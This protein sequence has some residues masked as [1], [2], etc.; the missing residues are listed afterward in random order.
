MYGTPRY[1]KEEIIELLKKGAT[2]N[3]IF[4]KFDIPPSTLN[5]WIRDLKKNIVRTPAEEKAR[6]RAVAKIV[7]ESEAKIMNAAALIVSEDISDK[8]WFDFQ[9]T[10]TAELQKLALKALD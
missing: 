7:N 6:F 9:M 4:S 5:L 2:K 1:D 3:E 10:I 8:Q